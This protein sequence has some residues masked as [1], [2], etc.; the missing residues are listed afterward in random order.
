MNEER[1]HCARAKQAT[2]RNPQNP[3]PCPRAHLRHRRKLVKPTTRRKLIA[4]LCALRMAARPSP[5]GATKRQAQ[6]SICRSGLVKIPPCHRSICSASAIPTSRPSVSS[7]CCAAPARTP[8]RTCAR[9]RRRAA[10]PGSPAKI[11]RPACS[12]KACSTAVRRHARRPA[13]R[14]GLYREGV[15]DYEAMAKA[16]GV[17]RRPRPIAGRSPR[18]IGSA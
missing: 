14:P 8:S 13:A 15:A 5:K 2:H 1:G 9:R 12:R 16:A 6:P 7:A 10:F 11:L 4:A 18:G 3:S 17:S